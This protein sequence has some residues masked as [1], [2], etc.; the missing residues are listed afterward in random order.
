MK[1]VFKLIGLDCANCATKIENSIQKIHNITSVNINFM[2]T[3]MIIEA[4]EDKMDDITNEVK[5]IIKKID[6]DIE[7]KKA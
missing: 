4:D 1:K 2:T 5:A 6:S 3:K 7:V